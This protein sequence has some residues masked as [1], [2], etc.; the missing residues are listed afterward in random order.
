M[1]LQSYRILTSIC[2]SIFFRDLDNLSVGIRNISQSLEKQKNE[3][4][5]LSE[6][7]LV[8][9]LHPDFDVSIFLF[10]WENIREVCL[11]LVS[12]HALESIRIKSSVALL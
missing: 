10:A 8:S 11:I 2:P 4:F 3:G 6:Y 12:S 9:D 7:I 5:D 1:E